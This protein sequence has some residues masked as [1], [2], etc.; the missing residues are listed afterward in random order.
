MSLEP[1]NIKLTAKQEAFCNEYLID[2]NASAAARRAGYSEET[3]GAI[4][5]E[6][7][8]KPE[9]QDR[10]TELR[11]KLDKDNDGLIQQVIDE[12]KKV[13]FSNIQDFIESG[14]S[15]KDLTQVDTGKAAAVASIKKSVTTFGDGEGNEGEKTV[16]EFKLWDK[17]SALEKLGRHLG[18]FEADNTQKSAVINVNMMDDSDDG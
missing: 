12:L 9:I 10:L 1:E 6:N 16:V 18:I 3:A 11:K 13:G 15:I 4:G 8:Q 7:L 5:W 17:L 14:N 2:L